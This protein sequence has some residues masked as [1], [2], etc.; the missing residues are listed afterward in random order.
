MHTSALLASSS[1]SLSLYRSRYIYINIKGTLWKKNWNKFG[2]G[3]VTTHIQTHTLQNSTSRKKGHKL[4]QTLKKH[5]HAQ[6]YSCGY[7]WYLWVLDVGTHGCGAQPFSR[8]AGFRE[9][10]V[11]LKTAFYASLFWSGFAAHPPSVLGSV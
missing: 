7:L 4:E 5:N 2:T 11:E 10:G 9:G 6:L 1:G 3:F 8:T